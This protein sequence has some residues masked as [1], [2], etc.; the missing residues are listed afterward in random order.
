LNKVVG[1]NFEDNGQKLFFF[2]KMQVIII[3]RKLK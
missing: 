3:I 1:C 2:Q